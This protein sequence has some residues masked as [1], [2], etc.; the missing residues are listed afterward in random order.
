MRDLVL[1]KSMKKIKQAG[2]WQEKKN[3]KIYIY[4]YIYIMKHTTRT[5]RMSTI[6]P[7][8][9]SPNLQLI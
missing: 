4:V 9:S 8:I 6:L 2:R 7:N 1:S 5:A 3:R